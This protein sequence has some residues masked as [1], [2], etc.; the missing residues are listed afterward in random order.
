MQMGGALAS[1]PASFHFDALVSFVG[2]RSLHNLLESSQQEP[3]RTPFW[4]GL[5][6]MS[7]GRASCGHMSCYDGV[8]SKLPAAWLP[9]E[10]DSGMRTSCALLT[11]GKGRWGFSDEV[12]GGNRDVAYPAI[13]QF[14]TDLLLIPLPAAKGTGAPST[15]STTGGTPT[16]AKYVTTALLRTTTRW[17]TS[18]AHVNRGRQVAEANG[19]VTASPSTSIPAGSGYRPCSEASGFVVN[20][21]CYS[22][23][24]PANSSYVWSG[25]W[26][27]ADERCR[28]LNGSLA[29]V[30]SAEVYD[31]LLTFLANWT[32]KG[33][34]A[35]LQN[36]PAVYTPVWMGLGLAANG[37]AACGFTYCF[38]GFPSTC[39]DCWLPGEP[40][41]AFASSCTQINYR[42]NRWGFYDEECGGAGDVPR[43]AL[44]RF[45]TVGGQGGAGN[46]NSPSP[47]RTP[48]PVSATPSPTVSFS[49]T[50]TVWA[51]WSSSPSVRPPITAAPCNNVTGVLPYGATAV[52]NG[53]A[54]GE[55]CYTLTPPGWTGTWQEVQDACSAMGGFGAR[56]D[57]YAEFMAAIDLMTVRNRTTQDMDASVYHVW[58]GLQSTAPAGERERY[59]VLG[60]PPGPS[61]AT[62]YSYAVAPNASYW[63]HGE[64]NNSPSC[65]QVVWATRSRFS[66]R[67]VGP[68]ITLYVMNVDGYGAG[69]EGGTGDPLAQAWEAQYGHFGLYDEACGGFFDMQWPRRGLCQYG[70][71]NITNPASSSPSPSASASAS[72]S[73]SSEPSASPLMDAS[74]TA[75]PSASASA[76][77]S[78]SYSL[79]QELTAT[80]TSTASA[81]SSASMT[82]MSTHTSTGSAVATGTA[83]SS[84]TSTWTVV[85]G[86]ETATA[87]ASS[88]ATG[89]ASA[90]SSALLE[91]P[92]PSVSPVVAPTVT[93]IPT[94]SPSPTHSPDGSVSSSPSPSNATGV[95]IGSTEKRGDSG[96]SSSPVSS[97]VGGGIAGGLLLAV[98]PVA[99]LLWAKLGR[100]MQKSHLT[101]R[102]KGSKS[103]G[104][105]GSRRVGKDWTTGAGLSSRSISSNLS[106]RLLQLPAILGGHHQTSLTR[107]HRLSDESSDTSQD[108]GA[109]GAP[110]G[111]GTDAIIDENGLLD[112]TGMMSVST[113]HSSHSAHG[114][115]GMGT[116]V[117]I[118]NPLESARSGRMLAHAPHAGPVQHAGHQMHAPS[119]GHSGALSVLKKPMAS[120]VAA[121][122]APVPMRNPAFAMSRQPG[123]EAGKKKVAFTS[124]AVSVAQGK[125]RKKVTFEVAPALA[126]ADGRTRPAKTVAFDVDVRHKARH[127]EERAH[128]GAHAPAAASTRMPD[129]VLSMSA[130]RPR[131]FLHQAHMDAAMHEHKEHV[132]ETVGLARKETTP[133]SRH[134]STILH[135][136]VLIQAAY[137]AWKVRMVMQGWIR[138]V[139]EDGDVYYHNRLTGLTEWVLPT[140]PFPFV[141]REP[142]DGMGSDLHV[143]QSPALGD[144]RHHHPG[145]AAVTR[146][147]ITGAHANEPGLDITHVY[148]GL[149]GR[150]HYLDGPGGPRLA[151]GWRLVQEGGDTWYVNEQGESSWEPQ[152][153]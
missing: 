87:S 36:P 81:T 33:Y 74:L 106:K 99:Y 96:G 132:G 98:L 131:G 3:S 42:S 85:Q 135:A 92:V 12:C 2:G 37:G 70:T 149:T 23:A 76:S 34:L 128:V 17:H 7:D 127:G 112:L 107:G 40:N 57:S 139:A 120:T 118:V 91:S 150:R 93:S 126:P 32:A 24:T 31:A 8:A 60:A 77:A 66:G 63:V 105:A 152:Y 145:Q 141:S 79:P 125:E 130:G 153:G 75:S 86:S 1:V 137:K 148:D 80:A 22:L 88:T 5:G 104:K 89:S 136:A 6:S 143:R 64:P 94:P 39:N 59:T 25:T 4:L 28:S 100:Q 121:I 114:H 19:T 95:D 18:A 55:V 144:T 129:A 115:G 53:I 116:G 123:A 84:A 20:G 140:A 35:A 45:D 54:T 72:S 58:T 111:T 82:P 78:A 146:M 10:P 48:P 117:G 119:R 124:E 122:E 101:G 102:D 51:S 65:L 97:A 15:G 142:H 90:T 49:S 83:L 41:S 43:P 47:S 50:P 61:G 67:P 134:S 68:L 11:Y 69:V 147:N 30:P 16:S 26:S 71:A 133:A 38:A 44:C 62:V 110:Y 151:H 27:Q 14:R 73:S 13:C 56:L 113:L 46:T 21:V 29:S 109:G 52:G 9:G 138:V 108:V 103:S